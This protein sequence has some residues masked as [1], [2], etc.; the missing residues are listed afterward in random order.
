MHTKFTA[1]KISLAILLV[2]LI[3]SCDSKPDPND[4]IKYLNG[5][6]EIDEAILPDGTVTKYSSN[7][8]V[9]Y[10]EVEGLEA[11]RKKVVPVPTG[12]FT[13]TTSEETFIIT[14]EEDSLRLYYATPFDSWK[15]TVINLDADEF[16]VRGKNNRIYIYKRY[17]F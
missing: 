5:F 7:I 4:S 15:E 9:D 16:R 14:V 1:I 12:G 2:A 13:R 11:T 6:W 17:S 10:I 3:S 8:T